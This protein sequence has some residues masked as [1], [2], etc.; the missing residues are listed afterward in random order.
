M[1]KKK[2]KEFSTVLGMQRGMHLNDFWYLLKFAKKF[3]LIQKF[4][5]WNLFF[6]N[7]H[8]LY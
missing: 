8:T 4:P 6:R 7:N 2:K 5:L 3:F 1:I